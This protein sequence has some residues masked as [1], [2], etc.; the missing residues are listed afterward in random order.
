MRRRLQSAL[1]CGDKRSVSCFDLFA[2]ESVWNVFE[3]RVRVTGTDI[4][5][6]GCRRGLGWQ[7]WSARRVS[8]SWN[9]LR[10]IPTCP[11]VV[12]KVT[13]GERSERGE[14]GVREG[15]EGKK[16]AAL[17]VLIDP[18][19]SQS[20]SIDLDLPDNRLMQSDRRRMLLI[21]HSGPGFVSSLLENI[22][23]R[24]YSLLLGYLLLL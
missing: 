22:L 1:F 3:M 10:L 16:S 8:S 17:E 11:L 23:L 9:S 4:R 6:S 15:K 12:I 13:G 20:F 21:F 19:S 2:K 14:E 24:T 18:L 5:V 7:P